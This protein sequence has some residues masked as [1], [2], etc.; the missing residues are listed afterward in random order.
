M[1]D[2]V[3]DRI[4]SYP[5][6]YPVSY[7]LYPV[8]TYVLSYIARRPRA[9]TVAH[10]GRP[11][12]HRGAGGYPGRAPLGSCRAGVTDSPRAARGGE[13]KSGATAERPATLD[14]PLSTVYC[15][16]TYCN[17]L[18]STGNYDILQYAVI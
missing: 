7:T 2:I 12:P 14:T 10:A 8:H 4:L 9:D 16:A 3:S 17:R 6:R 15:T 18:Q 1:Y 5:M 11:R 13:A